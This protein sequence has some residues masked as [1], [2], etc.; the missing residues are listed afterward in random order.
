MNEW[1]NEGIVSIHHLTNAEDNYLAYIEF[2]QKYP[3]VKTHFLM[4]G[5]LLMLLGNA[6]KE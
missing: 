3:N 1:F 6:N 2:K 4:Y 5:V